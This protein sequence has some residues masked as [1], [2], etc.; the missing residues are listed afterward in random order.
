VSQYQVTATLY[1]EEVVFG[2]Q[3]IKNSPHIRKVN[4]EGGRIRTVNMTHSA[5]P[6]GFHTSQLDL[7][8]SYKVSDKSEF[9]CTFILCLGKMI[10][11]FF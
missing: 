1:T 11:P 4:H 5:V 7:A 6:A 10:K 2:T 3:Y 8:T 9:I